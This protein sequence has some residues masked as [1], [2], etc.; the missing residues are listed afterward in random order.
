[1]YAFIMQR[2]WP[3]ATPHN[4]A[5]RSL[6]PDLMAAQGLSNTTF[7]VLLVENLPR[8]PP[9]AQP[10]TEWMH[11]DE[12][13]IIFVFAN[14]MSCREC[15]FTGTDYPHPYT[16]EPG[17]PSTAR[18]GRCGCVVCSGCVGEIMGRFPLAEEVPCPY[19]DVPQAFGRN[20]ILWIMNSTLMANYVRGLPA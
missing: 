14:C 20:R 19:C 16:V 15:N 7:N 11:A 17:H 2:Y 9:P 1:M 5:P 12:E 13:G 3:E 18:L 6:N 4:R 10:N 8:P